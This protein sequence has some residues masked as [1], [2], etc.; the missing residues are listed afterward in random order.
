MD[1]NNSTLKSI[2]EEK[3]ERVRRDEKRPPT[4]HTMTAY[5]SSMDQARS[6]YGEKASSKH[7]RRIS[8]DGESLC[9]IGKGFAKVLA[10][11]KDDEKAGAAR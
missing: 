6:T 1:T 4:Q 10:V 9:Y 7:H 8:A 5:V 11:H 2:P 3:P